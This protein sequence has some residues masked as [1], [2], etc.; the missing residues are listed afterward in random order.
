MRLARL[1]LGAPI[2]P[3][4]PL[5]GLLAYP[6]RSQATRPPQ[7]TFRQRPYPTQ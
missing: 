5:P 1:L 2:R 4:P 7:T 6:G 3:D